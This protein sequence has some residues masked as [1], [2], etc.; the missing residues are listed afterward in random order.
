MWRISAISLDWV[1]KGFHL[2]I[3]GVE[4][5]LRP[6]HLGG[7]LIVPTF[8]TTPSRK[9]VLAIAQARLLLDDPRFRRKAIRDAERAVD[10]LTKS[11]SGGLRE[12]AIGR[13][14][15]ISFLK[16]ALERLEP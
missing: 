10:Y 16:S 3:G 11:V 5:T 15:E 1:E 4:L 12:Q 6:D 9:A 14:A 7:I 2:H 13:A 8:S